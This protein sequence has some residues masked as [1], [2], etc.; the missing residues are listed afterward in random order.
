MVIETQMRIANN[1]ATLRKIMNLSQTAVSKKIVVCRSTYAQYE[2]GSRLP[3]LDSLSILADFYH[4]SMDT[5]VN[6]N[7]KTA[8]DNYAMQQEYRKEESHLLKLYSTLS[9]Y[10][11]R[12]LLKRAKEL[13]QVDATRRKEI[14]REICE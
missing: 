7:I 4:V 6:S 10:Q 3:D 11:K 14:Q 5:L 9:D 8:L 12:E 13:V 2:D 1:L